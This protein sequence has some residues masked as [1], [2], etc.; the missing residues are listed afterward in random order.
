MTDISAERRNRIRLSVAAYAYE[1]LADPIMSDK[2]YDE[3]AKKINKDVVTGDAVLDAF[4]KEHYSPDTGMWIY[5][6]PDPNG[7][8]KIYTTVWNRTIRRK[9]TAKHKLHS[10]KSLKALMTALN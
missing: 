1:V 2:E 7:L 3:L 6:H 5:K 10:I 9:L 8:E 4:F